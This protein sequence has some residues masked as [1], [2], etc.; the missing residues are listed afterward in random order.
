MKVKDISTWVTDAKAYWLTQVNAS[1]YTNKTTLTA[2]IDT[3]LD[4]LVTAHTS[5]KSSASL[6]KL[7]SAIIPLFSYATMKYTLIIPAA[8]AISTLVT[9]VRDWYAEFITDLPANSNSYFSL[10]PDGVDPSIG[11]LTTL[12]AYTTLLNAFGTYTTADNNRIQSFIDST[13]GM[14]TDK[15]L[16]M[17]FAKPTIQ[18][19]ADA[20]VTVKTTL[21]LVDLLTYFGW[22]ISGIN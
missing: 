8:P 14:S 4:A 6:S 13:T 16:Y 9:D 11:V 5:Y 12:T 1:V 2:S 19:G 18:T 15:T 17:M 20:D 10:A 7:K 21:H 3:Q 22:T